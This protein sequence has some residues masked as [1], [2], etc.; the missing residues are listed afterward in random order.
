MKIR[1]YLRLFILFQGLTWACPKVFSQVPSPGKAPDKPF[2]L[3]Y[4]TLHLGNGKTMEN[5][6]L[7]FS[8]GKILGI[9]TAQNAQKLQN[10]APGA[11]VLNLSGK[12]LYP[13]FILMNTTLGLNEVDAVRATVD[14]SET[15]NENPNANA[16]SAYNTD[17]DLIPTI[18]SNG[19][20]TAQ[21]TPSGNRVRGLSSVVQLD[22][23]NW[24]DAVIKERDGLHISWPSKYKVSGWWAEPGQ[25]PEPNKEAAKELEAL[26]SLFSEAEVYLKS[27]NKTLNT[28]LEAFKSV[29]SGETRV[30]LHAFYPADIVQALQFA[31][32]RNLPKISLVTGHKVVQVLDLIKERKVPVVLNRLH[33]L[34]TNPEDGV[35]STIE[36]CKTLWDNQVL[37]SIDYEGDME[38]MGSRNLGF[39]AGATQR[40]GLSKEQALQLITENPAKILGIE[41]QV[42]TLEVGKDATFFISE[43]DALDMKTQNI[44]QAWIQGR[45]ISLESKQTGLYEKFKKMLEQGR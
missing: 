14:K 24:E 40:F 1:F 15:G 27:E 29:F 23:W 38:V 37:F 42:G 39:M 35:H 30:Y 32:R 7:L 25:G 45:P 21:I 16:L 9:E 13:G 12:H 36:I 31:K 41:N 18:R 11:E 43:E 6:C 44:T 8:K 26:E 34:P 22:A 28:R 3:K 17:S 5:G 20:L 10:M 2:I 33:S 4:A 19:I